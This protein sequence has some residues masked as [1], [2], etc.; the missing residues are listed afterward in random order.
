MSAAMICLSLTIHLRRLGAVVLG[1]ID[2]RRGH[3]HE[4][5]WSEQR[6]TTASAPGRDASSPACPQERA[7]A[8]NPGICRT[9]SG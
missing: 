3:G 4:E 9:G 5:A 1:A 2:G 7:R 8:V 6:H